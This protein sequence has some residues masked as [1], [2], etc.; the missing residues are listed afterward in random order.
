MEGLSPAFNNTSN[1]TPPPHLEDCHNNNNNPSG[2]SS[3]PGLKAKTSTMMMSSSSSDIE[4]FQGKIVYNPDGSAYIIEDADLSEDEALLDLPRQEGSITEKPGQEPAQVDQFPTIENAIYVARTKSN[5]P[6]YVR[7]QAS[8][9]LSDRPT[10]HSYRVYNYRQNRRGGDEQQRRRGPLDTEAAVGTADNVP[11]KPILMC[12]ICKL[13]FG[14]SKSFKT[15]CSDEHSRRQQQH[16]LPAAVRSTSSYSAAFPSQVTRW[17]GRHSGAQR[18]GCFWWWQFS[19]IPGFQ[20]WTEQHVARRPQFIAL[21]QFF[22]PDDR[23][24]LWKGDH[25]WRLPRALA[26]RP[27]HRCRMCQVRSHT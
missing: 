20:W 2:R 14:N 24:R 26:G 10:V 5:Y 4:E 18:P 6:S 9:L 22:Q 1:S 13:S 15:H 27:A 7:A 3:S 12:F 23:W 16:R 17:R 11:V 19:N 8:R 21:P 25:Y